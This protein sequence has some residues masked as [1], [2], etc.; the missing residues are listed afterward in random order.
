MKFSLL[1]AQPGEGETVREIL[2]PA[3]LPAG[4]RLKVVIPTDRLPPYWAGRPMKIEPSFVG[5]GQAE[6]PAEMADL[7]LSIEG[8]PTD[9]ARTSTMGAQGEALEARPRS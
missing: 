9:I 8:A 3:D 1:D 4:T 2:V 6:A 7:K 5:V